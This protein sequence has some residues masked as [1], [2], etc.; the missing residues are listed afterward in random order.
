MNMYVF[1]YPLF[2]VTCMSHLSFFLSFSLTEPKLSN[3]NIEGFTAKSQFNTA[4]LSPCNA[5]NPIEDTD[6]HIEGP[7]GC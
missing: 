2:I 5:S 3:E 1:L 7:G 4:A 6:R